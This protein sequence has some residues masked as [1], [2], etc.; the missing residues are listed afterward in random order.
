MRLVVGLFCSLI[1]S[2]G[3]IANG[4]P[5]AD[6][7]SGTIT[8]SCEVDGGR[9]FVSVMDRGGFDLGEYFSYALKVGG[10]KLVV[11]DEGT[12]ISRDLFAVFGR[13]VVTGTSTSY[14][15]C[16]NRGACEGRCCVCEGEGDSCDYT[17]SDNYT[18]PYRESPTPRKQKYP[19]R[20]TIRLAKKDDSKVVVSYIRKLKGDR[21]LELDGKITK[22]DGCILTWK[23]KLSFGPIP[24]NW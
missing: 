22:A 10:E 8:N 9:S 20:T 18:P 21:S 3:V 17:G 1:F 6:I 13:G 23:D 2:S 24:S 15:D 14:E 12:V 11:V 7:G 19:T 4:V 5:S 16:P